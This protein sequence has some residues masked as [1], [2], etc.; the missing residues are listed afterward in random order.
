MSMF[1]IFKTKYRPGLAPTRIEALTD[2][3][4]GFAIT[5]LVL[6]LVVPELSEAQLS[7]GALLSYLIALLPKF[8]TY[9]VSALVISIFWIGHTILFAF[10]KK[11]D[12]FFML[13]NVF[14]IITIGFFPFP[15]ALLGKYPYQLE[16]IVLYGATLVTSGLLFASIWMYASHKRHL[17]SNKLSDALI[18]KGNIIVAVAPV[19]YFLAVLLAFVVPQL[20]LAI[21]AI[22]PAIYV[23]PSVVDEL[24]EAGAIE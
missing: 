24:V 15:V 7:S 2:S 20:T 22:V 13:L 3:I 8:V 19:V 17:I 23:V 9:L 18:K 12:R 14:F 21:Y 4:F 11:T 5:L 6:A 16:A 1:S 10:V